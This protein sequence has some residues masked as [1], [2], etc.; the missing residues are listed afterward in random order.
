MAATAAAAPA[1]TGATL[2]V[3]GFPGR[4]ASDHGSVS[5]TRRAG[6]D[7]D[8]PAALAELG[9]LVS[10]VV[11]GGTSAGTTVMC[12]A[13]VVATTGCRNELVG[14]SAIGAAATGW[15]GVGKAAA[16]CVV[17]VEAG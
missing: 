6:L 12:R 15:R 7:R 11:G 8:A 10:A 2:G 3:P 1:D 5:G 14:A 4:G 17:R 16:G 9:R 13:G